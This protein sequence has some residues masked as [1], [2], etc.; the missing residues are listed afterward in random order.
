MT[1]PIPPMIRLMPGLVL[2]ATMLTACSDAEED[3]EGS[4]EDSTPVTVERV[5]IEQVEETERSMARSEAFSS[6][7]VSAE[8]GGRVEE[9]LHDIGDRVDS[10][11]EL[12]RL[13]ADSYRFALAAAQADAAALQARLTQYERELDRLA[14]V[15]EGVYVSESDFEA[16]E[17]DVTT[18]REELSAAEN[19]RD[20]AARELERTVI[21]APLAGRI[22]ERMISEGDYVTVGDPIFRMVPDASARVS[23]PFPE[24]VAGRLEAGMPAR[25][26]PLEADEGDWIDGEVTRLR[27]SVD[28][29]MGVVAIVEFEPP[30]SWR[31]GTMLEGQVIVERREE[32]LVVPSESVVDRPDRNVIFVLPGDNSEKEGKVEER[33]VRR[34]YRTAEFTEI[35]EGV[36]ADEQVVVD[37][38]AF[39]GDGSRVRITDT[40]SGEGSPAETRESEDRS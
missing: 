29:G 15:G 26:R 17:A 1:D 12:A 38:A 5:Q 32:A 8:V 11:A 10:G 24:R 25:V 23:L 30:E 18:T 36:E 21:H 28:G 34:G 6:P 27:P 14:S 2:A 39:I 13:E 16:A 35:V 20:E 9:I 33:E 31:S 22:D 19:R 40:G 3:G 7:V 37:G 4:R